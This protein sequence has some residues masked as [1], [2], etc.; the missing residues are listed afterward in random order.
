MA[1]TVIL[2]CPTLKG[3]LTSALA[4]ASSEAIVYFMP[5]RLHSDPKELHDY[6][7]DMIDHFRNVDRIVLCVSGCGGGTKGLK[8]STAELVVPRTRD[9]LDILLSGDSLAALQRDI[10]GVYFTESWMEFSKNSDIDLDKLIRKMGRTDAEDYL[11]RLF[12][13]CNKFYVIDTGCYDVQEVQEYIAPLVKIL[14]GTVTVLKGEY[15]ILRKIARGEFDDDFDI[16]PKGGVR[17]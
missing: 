4:E 15:G 9:C 6:M 14:D 7:Q 1:K 5:Q 13:T 2:S 10:T 8:A 3:E 12:K 16:V 17:G 11:R